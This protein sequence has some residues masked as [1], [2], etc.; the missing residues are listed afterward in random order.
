MGLRARPALHRAIAPVH[1]RQLNR[2][3]GSAPKL[4]SNKNH[5][6]ILARGSV[7]L[8]SLMSLMDFLDRFILLLA[9]YGNYLTQACMTAPLV[10][11]QAVLPY[12]HPIFSCASAKTDW[13]VPAAPLCAHLNR[14]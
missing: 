1:R 6:A 14:C 12:R 13:T 4:K 10:Y 7:Y 2:E 3:R 8:Y 9:G 11:R 5:K